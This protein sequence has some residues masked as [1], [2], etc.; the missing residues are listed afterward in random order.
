[1]H[2]WRQAVMYALASTG[3]VL[4]SIVGLE[5]CYS[6]APLKLRSTM[7]AIWFLMVGIA[8]V[9]PMFITKKEYFPAL[10][11]FAKKNYSFARKN[12]II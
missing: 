4:I 12:F 8:N 6:E 5:Y 11:V 1:M 9:P 10:T 2:I 7:A 3:E